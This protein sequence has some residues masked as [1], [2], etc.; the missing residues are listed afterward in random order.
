[1]A[2]DYSISTYKYTES[3]GKPPAVP[4]SG[5]ASEA[6][7]SYTRIER[8]P[9]LGHQEKHYFSE[10]F[11]KLK[12]NIKTCDEQNLK[13]VNRDKTDCFMTVCDYTM[14]TTAS[15]Q[16]MFPGQVAV[17]SPEQL[18]DDTEVGDAM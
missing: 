8:A 16:P 4:G 10:M 1:M 9:K 14:G 12:I 17:E 6:L 18:D 11:F 15:N 13:T 3:A 5:Q 7:I 2:L